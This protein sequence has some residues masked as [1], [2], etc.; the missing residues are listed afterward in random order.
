MEEEKLLEGLGLTKGEIK[1]YFALLEIGSSTT[2]EIIKKA[3]VSRSK[4]YEMLDRLI[5][6]GLVSFVIKENTKYFEA[7]DPDH[8][9][10]YVRRERSLLEEK[11]KELKKI[12][13]TLKQKK[14]SAK[15][16]QTST[17]YEGIKG[18]KT[19]YSEVLYSLEK[20]G[21]YYAIAAEPD[22]VK[23]KLFMTF[24][25]NFHRRREELGIKVNLLASKRI[26]S[27]VSKMFSKS[28]FM[29]I[30]YFEQ[31]I[32]SAML[33]YGDNVATYVWGERP[34]GVVIKSETIAKR[35]REFFQE[36]WRASK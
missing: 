6:R 30:K 22:V 32:P 27:V 24:I 12:L 8:I 3:K 14:K 5:D 23:D 1:V 36:V 28:K 33:I 26:K 11:E 4:V 21:E 7:A 16:P 15:T 13:P 19:I 29:K 35:Y 10:H 31:N 20:N 2:G 9:L 17:V 18:I 34:S 25:K